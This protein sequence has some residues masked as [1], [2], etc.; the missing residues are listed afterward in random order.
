MTSN[1]SQDGFADIE[2]DHRRVLD[3]LDDYHDAP[4]DGLAHH[5]CTELA[6]HARAEEVTLYVRLRELGS[7]ESQDPD[8]VDGMALL[9]R[10]LAEHSEVETQVARVLAAPPVD[11]TEVM[12]HIRRG[13]GAHVGFEEAEILPRLR[14]LLDAE[15]LHS[16]FAA[17][18]EAARSAR[19]APLY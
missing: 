12:A 18:K 14:T 7:G 1:E 5:I 17:A 9:D 8:I 4:D 16:D 13:I 10:A 6:V 15:T 11:L 2:A 3:L 19:G